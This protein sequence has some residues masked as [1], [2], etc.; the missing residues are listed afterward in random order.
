MPSGPLPDSPASR[1]GAVSVMAGHG[2]VPETGRPDA[3][4][5]AQKQR[6]RAASSRSPFWC[7]VRRE[8]A[9][10][11]TGA[12]RRWAPPGAVR[13]LPRHCPGRQAGSI[14]GTPGEEEEPAESPPPSSARAA[15][16]VRVGRPAR[17][18]DLPRPE[19]RPDRTVP[20]G[21][22]DRAIPAGGKPGSPGD[23]R[24]QRS[25]GLPGRVI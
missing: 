9:G 24:A 16:Q 20:S 13:P 4:D 6:H 12:W 7:R 8:A 19:T 15:R 14:R 17:A 1:C 10:R 23:S 11:R 18:L 22:R 25:C 5:A 2:S 3:S 21:R